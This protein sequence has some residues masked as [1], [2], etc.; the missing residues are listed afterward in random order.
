MTSFRDA[1]ATRTVL[2]P[3][4]NGTVNYWMTGK[5]PGAIDPSGTFHDEAD[6]YSVTFADS[7]FNK[8]SSRQP[9]DPSFTPSAEWGSGNG[10]KAVLHRIV[11]TAAVSDVTIELP[12]PA[13]TTV[14]LLGALTGTAGRIYEFAPGILLPDGFRVKIVATATTG[15]VL[16][17]Y[18]LLEN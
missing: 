13:A 4:I 3:S 7:V 16:V 12:T 11:I 2:L 1:A 8:L 9:F 5:V 10:K 15:R 6:A 17:V 18:S 14:V